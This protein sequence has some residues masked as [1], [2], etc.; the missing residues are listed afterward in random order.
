[1]DARLNPKDLLQYLKPLME[2]LAEYLTPQEWK[3][4]TVA[5]YEYRDVFSSGTTDMG[6][7][8][9]VTRSIDIIEETI[10]LTLRRFPITTDVDQAELEKMLGRGVIEPCHSSWTEI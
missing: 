1:M 2:G 5:I 8:D 7:T 3:E 4:P 6:R 9:L 10:R